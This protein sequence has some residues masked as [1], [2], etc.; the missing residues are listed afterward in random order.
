M[1]VRPSAAKMARRPSRSKRT[2]EWL[3]LSRPACSDRK[4]R[5]RWHTFKPV[6]QSDVL[7]RPRLRPLSSEEWQ[8]SRARWATQPKR[9]LLAQSS[10]YCD[11]F[12]EER[13]R[14][15]RDCAGIRWPPFKSGQSAVHAHRA[16]LLAKNCRRPPYP[17][18]NERAEST[19][20]ASGTK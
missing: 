10:P 8:W 3:H 17:C 1:T 11:E 9:S 15:P 19:L 5:S 4:C 16:F 13:W 6:L 12:D 14:Q 20:E 18:V 2:I 7:G